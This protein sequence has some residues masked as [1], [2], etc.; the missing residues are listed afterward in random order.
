MNR[1]AFRLALPALL[2]VL[3]FMEPRVLLADSQKEMTVGITEKLDSYIP[4]N[5]V[6]TDYTGKEFNLKNLVDKPTVLNF[7]YFR[8]PGICSPLMN[9]LSEVI[10]TS[11]LQLGKDYQVVTISFDATEGPDLAA[12]KRINYM[13]RLEHPEDSMGWNFCTADSLNIANITKATGFGFKRAG[14]EFMHEGALILLSPDGKITRYLKGISFLPFEFKLA[15]LEAN[16]GKSSPTV[17][18]VIKFCFSYDAGSQRY[19]LDIT[20]ISATLII[21]FAVV[22]LLYLLIRSNKDKRRRNK[23][24][25]IASGNETV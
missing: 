5:I 3:L 15:V 1:L 10:N 22:L 18:S 16:Q 8:C 11:E 13:K 17:S 12:K 25:D 9:G 24:S 4:A 19:V 14:N 2:A 6:L 23:Q 7:V 21:F 20:K